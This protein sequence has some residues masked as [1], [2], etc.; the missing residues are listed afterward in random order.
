M[1]DKLNISKTSIS[2]YIFFTII[3]LCK[4]FNLQSESKIYVL[5][6]FFGF[7][8]VVIK[9]FRD[10]YSRKEIFKML[11]LYAFSI[12]VFLVSKNP[13]PLFFVIA[14]CCLKGVDVNKIIKLAFFTTVFSTMCMIFLSSTGLI[15]NRIVHLTRDGVLISRYSFGYVHP[16]IVQMQLFIIC[17]MYYYIYNNK[18]N[19]II[20]I[21]FIIINFL[22]FKYT[23]S[24]TSFYLINLFIIYQLF[25]KNIKVI[26]KIIKKYSKYSFC[27]IFFIS[28]LLS[29][30]Y[31]NTLWVQHLD[32]FF[33]GRIYYGAY[34][35]NHYSVPIFGRVYPDVMFDN[36]Y[37]YLLFCCGL[38]FTL[39]YSFLF[40]KTVSY[41]QKKE[42]YN[43]LLYLLII[44]IFT[45]SENIFLS[46]NLNFTNY[47]MSYIIFENKNEEKM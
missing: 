3:F 38:L 18:K 4:G 35:L 36:S 25:F 20:S 13:S 9:M 45:F 39:L 19:Y 47:F 42:K 33:T 21:I 6:Y 31:G 8:I 12:M 23:Y 32:I 40:I 30:L 15:E 29:K 11:L 26:Q 16:N 22:L 2:V 44:S 28:L 41:F 24:R 37:I 10:S 17:L 5:S 43:E 14:I 1:K 46:P 34:L 27:L 7:I